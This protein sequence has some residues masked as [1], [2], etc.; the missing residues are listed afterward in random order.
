[1]DPINYRIAWIFG[2]IGPLLFSTPC[3]AET[4]CTAMIDATLGLAWNEHSNSAAPNTNWQLIWSDEFSGSQIDQSLWSHE[5]GCWGGGN[6]EKQCYTDHEANSFVK[7]GSLHIV[8]RREE[9][10]GRAFPL[11][12]RSI[13]S[14]GA[15]RTLPYTSARL[16]TKDQGDWRYGRFEARIRLPGGQGTWPAFWMLPTDR[17]YGN[18]PRSG[19]IDIMEAVN[20]GARCPECAGGTEN[21]VTGALHFNDASG[22]RQSSAKTFLAD[23]TAFHTYAVEWRPNSILW[24]VDD[25]QFLTIPIEAWTDSDAPTGA[26]FNQRF[27]IILN[28]AIGGDWP[29]NVNELG[30][31]A[32]G[33]P[34]VM[35]IDWV[36]VYRCSVG[37]VGCRSTAGVEAK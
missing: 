5:I 25:Q 30:I 35:Q 31:D 3:H 8:A 33:F 20:L 14:E 2:T 34:K 13:L 32:R 22:I 24:F 12:Q 9:H 16:Q 6:N 11:E 1:M 27:H 36:R 10:T 7:D 17:T 29:E 37:D 28:L 19:E 21:R 23:P 15:T 18:W 4:P 26:P